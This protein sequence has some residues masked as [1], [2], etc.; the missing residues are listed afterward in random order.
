[1]SLG[2]EYVVGSLRRAV[3]RHRTASKLFDSA[4]WKRGRPRPRSRSSSVRRCTGSVATS[5]TPSPRRPVRD[6]P[7]SADD[8]VR[9]CYDVTRDQGAVGILHEMGLDP[10][11]S[12]SARPMPR[13][14]LEP[15]ARRPHR[16]DQRDRRP[17]ARA[18]RAR[19][20]P[21]GTRRAAC[22]ATRR[23][24]TAAA[25]KH[26]QPH[27][28]RRPRGHP[29]GAAV[30]HPAGLATKGR[31][32]AGR[33]RLQPALDRRVDGAHRVPV[34]GSG[35]DRQVPVR[36]LRQVARPGRAATA[37]AAAPV[38]GAGRLGR[39]VR[40]AVAECSSSSSSTTG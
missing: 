38:P 34:A 10:W 5:R 28:V 13:R 20:P 15:H 19:R 39:V 14:G 29:G 18:H 33:S 21:V 27:H 30:Q 2:S 1:M 17:G 8:D 16:R 3:A 36:F 24:R 9:G 40:A 32:P 11:W 7:R 31:G 6:R 37:R 4:V 35:E 12:T 26:R 23:R 25:G 22:S